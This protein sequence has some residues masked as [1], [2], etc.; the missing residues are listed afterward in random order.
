MDKFEFTSFFMIKYYFVR[1]LPFF[2]LAILTGLHFKSAGVL[3][4]LLIVLYFPH[5]NL[6]SQYKITENGV[7]S[8]LIKI[9][10]TSNY[11]CKVF[12]PEITMRNLKKKTLRPIICIGNISTGN[13]FK[14]SILRTVC[15]PLTQRNLKLLEKYYNNNNSELKTILEQ[16]LGYPE[17]PD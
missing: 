11:G 5:R 9:N 8:R 7:Q 1:T 4:L 13:L 2:L 12:F 17:Y 6:I 14:Q 10:W 16:Y 3:F 15:I